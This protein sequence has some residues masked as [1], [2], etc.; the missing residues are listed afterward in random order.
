MS[1]IIDSRLPLV[2]ERIVSHKDREARKG[3]EER[4]T[5]VFVVRRG[6]D[7]VGVIRIHVRTE[8]NPDYLKS[9]S[10][11]WIPAKPYCLLFREPLNMWIFT[12]RQF[13]NPCQPEEETAKYTKGAKMEK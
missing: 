13:Y 10:N 9:F 11:H 7:C 1:R 6:S 4:S 3:D 12:V 2:A 5:P 8:A